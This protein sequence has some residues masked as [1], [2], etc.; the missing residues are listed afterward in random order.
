M[1]T[2]CRFRSQRTASTVSV[3]AALLA[4]AGL[5]CF[6]LA[7]SVPVPQQTGA[8]A[9]ESEQIARVTITNFAF[10]PAT[11]T[12]P[13]GTELVWTNEDDAPHTV[14]GVD[15]DS[16]I[17]SKPLDTG[18]GYS[19]VLGRPGTYQYFCTLHPMMVGTIVVQ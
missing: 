18:D 9:P 3:A 16:P 2:L 7:D 6:A 13:V 19:V 4:A 5:S 14:T 11:L 8:Q 17:G 12:V 15:R 1:T 10:S